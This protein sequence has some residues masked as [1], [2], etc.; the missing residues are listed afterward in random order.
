MKFFWIVLTADC[1]C[2]IQLLFCFLSD[3]HDNYDTEEY[4][5]TKNNEAHSGGIGITKYL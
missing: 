5:A 4:L 2:Q 1:N 3:K